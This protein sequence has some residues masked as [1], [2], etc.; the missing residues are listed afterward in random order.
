MERLSQTKAREKEGQESATKQRKIQFD[1]WE[2]LQNKEKREESQNKIDVDF[3]KREQAFK[4][5]KYKDL[6]DLKERDLI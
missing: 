3:R 6:C 5:K 4:E 1:R 2:Y